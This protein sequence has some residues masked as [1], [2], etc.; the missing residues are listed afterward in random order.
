M[1]YYKVVQRTYGGDGTFLPCSDAGQNVAGG[2]F[3]YTVGKWAYAKS[4]GFFVFNNLKK[5]VH[6]RG[7]VCGTHIFEVDVAI[8]VKV[9]KQIIM[10]FESRYNVFQMVRIAK[11]RE[12]SL[13]QLLNRPGTYVPFRLQDP[14]DG[15]ICFRKV[16]LTRRVK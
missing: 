6:F 14:I 2:E 16:K 5:A 11:C 13:W 15:S 9:P 8:P 1:T 3:R 12:I 7:T 4:G 10:G